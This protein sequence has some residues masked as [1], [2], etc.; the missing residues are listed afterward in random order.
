MMAN[1]YH[2]ASMVWAWLGEDSA[3]CEAST[4]L[5]FYRALVDAEHELG[6]FIQDLEAKADN[7]LVYRF[8]PDEVAQRDDRFRRLCVSND[9]RSPLFKD[10][11]DHKAAS[12]WFRQHTPQKWNRFGGQEGSPLTVF[13]CTSLFFFLKRAYFGRRW[14]LQELHQAQ[15]AVVCCGEFEM[16]WT[17]FRSAHLSATLLMRSMAAERDLNVMGNSPLFADS[18][19]STSQTDPVVALYERMRACSKAECHDPRDVVYAL[20]SFDDPPA[21]LPDYTLSP[22]QLWIELYRALIA[23]GHLTR[24]ILKAAD[25]VDSPFPRDTQSP[26]WLSDFSITYPWHYFAFDYAYI[27][28]EPSGDVEARIDDKERLSCPLRCLGEVVF[29]NGWAVLGPEVSQDVL[30]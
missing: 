11:V 10:E 7:S 15:H 20:L 6:S 25:Q 13:V 17:D 9:P 16:D 14:V 18:L 22:R 30:K 5:P 27:E 21:M 28:N 26:S 29:H 1:I 12:D 19:Q 4:V 2:S 8:Q 3:W 23:R 24:L